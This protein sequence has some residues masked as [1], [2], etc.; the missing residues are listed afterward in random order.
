MAMLSTL[1]LE[2]RVGASLRE[3]ITELSIDLFD[4]ATL[5][6]HTLTV[7]DPD[8]GLLAVVQLQS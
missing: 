1:N 3:L 4:V 2:Y 5:P 6:L 7:S 8:C